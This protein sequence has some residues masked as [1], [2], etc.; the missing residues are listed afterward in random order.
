MKR[1]VLV[2]V[3]KRLSDD[4]SCGGRGGERLLAA[5]E[6]GVAARGLEVKVEPIHCFSRCDLGPVVRIAPGGDFFE[7][8][9]EGDLAAILDALD[10]LES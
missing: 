5:L 1:S 6:R 3:H 4:A 7:G 10:E 2:C 8:V 9:E